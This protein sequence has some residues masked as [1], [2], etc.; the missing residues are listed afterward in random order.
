MDISN[1]EQSMDDVQAIY[2]A[3]NSQAKEI[4]KHYTKSLD[5]LIKNINDNINNLSNDD[6]RRIELKLS[7]IS[8]DLGELKDKTSIASEVAEIIEAE[9]IATSFNTATGTIEQRKNIAI[10]NASK[11]KAVSKLY[12]LVAS[13]IK[14]KLDEVHRI[15][16]C[17]KSILISRASDRKLTDNYEGRINVDVPTEFETPS[18]DPETG[19]LR[20]NN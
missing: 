5:D 20:E 3:L 7:L 15:V 9:T 16:D 14:T 19:E 1:L 6:L 12:K 13:Q 10:L 18:F 4:V 2:D 8:Y 17:L 11:E